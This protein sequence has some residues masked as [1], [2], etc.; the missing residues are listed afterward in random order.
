MIASRGPSASLMWLALTVV[1]AV[2]LSAHTS[3]PRFELVLLIP[4]ASRRP[5]IVVT[6]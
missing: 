6:P 5:L 3:A 2:S 1:A 4:S